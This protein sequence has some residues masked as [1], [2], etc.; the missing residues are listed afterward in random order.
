MIENIDVENIDVEKADV[1]EYQ[2]LKISMLKKPMLKMPMLKISTFE[3]ANRKKPV[4]SKTKKA[5]TFSPQPFW[6]VRYVFI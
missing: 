2:R 4:F 6:K 3:N 1:E 5:V